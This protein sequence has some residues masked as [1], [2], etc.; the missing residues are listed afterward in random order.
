MIL[1]EN[2]VRQPDIAIIHKSCVNLITNRGIKGNPELVVEILSPSS[3]KR[4]RKDKLN[5]YAKYGIHEY[6][7][8]DPVQMA[9]EQYTLKGNSYILNEVYTGEDTIQSKNLSC[10]S[11]SMDDIFSGIPELPNA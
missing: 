11:F 5:T 6:W 10:V 2:E 1:S 7:L 4:D 9:L 8:I 3:I